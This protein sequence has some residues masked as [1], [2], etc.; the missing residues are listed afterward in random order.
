MKTFKQY[1]NSEFYFNE[2]LRKW[3]SKT[4]P[5]GGWKRVNSKGEV[6]GPCAREPGEAKPKCMSNR[7]R[8]RLSKKERAAAVKSKR[9]HDPVVDRSGKG[10]KPVNVSNF[11]KGKISEQ[12]ITLFFPKAKEFKEACWDT[13]KQVGMKKKGNKM[14]PNCVPKG[15]AEEIGGASVSTGS[16]AVNAVG[17]GNI[18]GIGFGV[19]DEPG[20][21]KHLMIKKV[22]RRKKLNVDSKIST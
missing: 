7:T 2:D 19:D 12:I 3:F 11:G 5:D 22:L 15:V 20:G 13:H 21:R 10:G 18:D 6:V 1:S 16:V 8:A 17:R 14:V 9:R 4:D